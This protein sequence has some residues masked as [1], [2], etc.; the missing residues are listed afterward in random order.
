MPAS[1]RTNPDH[2]PSVTIA[3]SRVMPAVAGVPSVRSP[4]RMCRTLMAGVSH[5]LERGQPASLGELLPQ[6]LDVGG[7]ERTVG[8]LLR[9]PPP[10]GIVALPALATQGTLEQLVGG[11]DGQCC[12]DADEPRRPL[13]AEVGLRR[14]E[15]A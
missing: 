2:M 14:A 4:G 12:T 7:G 1:V 11:R 8:E 15:P 9:R 6:R 13:G 10:H 5:S 3:C